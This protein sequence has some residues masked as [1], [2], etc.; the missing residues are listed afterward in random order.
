MASTQLHT[1]PQAPPTFTLTSTAII[2]SITRLIQAS[3]QAH[4]NLT[5]AVTVQSATFAKVL[6]PLAHAENALLSESNL[7]IFYDSVSTDKQ[8]RDASS[9]ARS[10]LRDY[11]TEASMDED[12]FRLVD[13]VY[14]TT[15]NESLTAEQRNFLNK[16][17]KEFVKNGLRI[18]PGPKRERF[19]HIRSRIDTLTS[20][21]SKN[22]AEDKTAVYFHPDELAGFPK[23]SLSQ[24]EK[25]Q[26]GTDNEGKVKVEI[27]MDLAALLRT[28]KSPSTRKRA[29]LAFDNRCPA[30]IAVFS[31]VVSL[32]H[33]AAQLL[34]YPNH[35]TLSIEDKM[36][37]TPAR[38]NAFLASLR[39]KL[40]DC[41][42][43]EA[44]TLLLLKTHDVEARGED[45][46]G[47][48]FT[49]DVPFYDNLL[50]QKEYSVDHAKISEYF[51]L[52]STVEGMLSTFEHLFGIVFH[53]IHDAERASLSLTGKG[54]DLLWNPDVQLFAAWDSPS[55]GG[56]FLGYIY[57]DLYHRDG[58]SRNPANFSLVP[59]FTKPD[60]KRV[61]PSTALICSFPKPT[62][63]KPTLLRHP[64]VVILFHE[65]GH[66]IHD[67]VSRTQYARFHGPMG[68]VVDFGEAPSQVLENWCWTPSQLTSLSKHYSHL[69]DKYLSAWRATSGGAAQQP[70]EELPRDMVDSLLRARHVG[71]AL[72]TLHQLFM[73]VFDMAVHKP[74]DDFE[75][76]DFTALWTAL[77]REIV[78]TQDPFVL[79]EGDKWGHGYT[80][81]TH[82]I[83]EYDAGFYSYLF[84]KVY[85]QDIFSTIFEQDPMSAEAGRK[86]RYGV[87]EKGGS[88]P[89]MTTLMEFLGRE[90]KMEPFYEDLGLVV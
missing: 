72:S 31:E 51:P 40:T 43:Q 33:E 17:H 81:I 82:F 83:K 64:D 3:K 20:Q 30:N 75:S 70:A 44:E 32:R 66:G 4:H 73:G 74:G 14:N 58:K 45:F 87:L 56:E 10:M 85:A 90:A 9:K 34:G 54:E 86:Y 12:V 28:T 67:L 21:F 62:S 25:G 5:N 80:N 71:Q 23:D 78:P 1:P 65:L 39:S 2:E 53:E 63:A 49:W 77:R 50:L 68:T 37:E 41:G 76:V 46:D 11:Q 59:G 19:K 57:L 61:Y 55:E 35:A 60:G 8:V 36:A 89:E 48:F 29:R 38:V 79:G 52:Q 7:L 42:K 22:L 47:R 18:P 84:S 24:L 27:P 13:A 15:A 16:K 26:P 6:L 69:S 88:Q